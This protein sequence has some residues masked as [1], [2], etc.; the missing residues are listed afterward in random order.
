[1]Q[2]WK[3]CLRNSD[4]KQTAW[5]KK[6]EKPNKTCFNIDHQWNVNLQVR[7]DDQSQYHHLMTSVFVDRR[8]VTVL[9]SPACKKLTMKKF[10]NNIKSSLEQRVTHTQRHV[11]QK[12]KDKFPKTESSSVF[13]VQFPNGFV[14]VGGLKA[15]GYIQVNQWMNSVWT[16]CTWVR[17]AGNQMTSGLEAWESKSKASC[18]GE[19]SDLPRFREFVLN[20]TEFGIN[21]E[22][23]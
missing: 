12:L 6:R 8:L 11:G 4:W 13:F 2:Y 22:S 9:L 20:S 23:Q 7:W 14:T 16:A 1:M 21:N 19:I 15:L 10:R 5:S 18:R 17:V 3:S